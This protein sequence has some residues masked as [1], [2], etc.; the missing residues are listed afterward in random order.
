MR[1]IT[2]ESDPRVRL[3][4]P[5]WSPR[6]DRINFLSTRNSTARE[7]RLWLVNP[8]GT[9]PRDLGIGA[10]TCWSG[11]GQWLYYQDSQN[12]VLRIRKVRIDGGQIVTV[13]TDNA[14]AARR[15][16]MALPC[17]MRGL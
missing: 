11:D 7:L 15:H 4:V 6:G 12:G 9:E 2:R 3:A 1:Q 8:D 13:R 16:L 5:F 17:S 14:S 10:G